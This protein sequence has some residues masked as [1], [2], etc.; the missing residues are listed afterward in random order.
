MKCL[1][2]EEHILIHLRLLFITSR[3]IYPQLTLRG[4]IASQQISQIYCP[5]CLVDKL[6]CRQVLESNQHKQ[7]K[8]LAADENGIIPNFQVS[9][10][11]WPT[12]SKMNGIGVS[13]TY[14][15][16]CFLQQSTVVVCQST[17]CNPESARRIILLLYLQGLPLMLNSLKL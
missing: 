11:L 2:P 9:I 1:C 16:T 12:L 17:L 14:C 7:T 3:W 13:V 6:F 15:T 8:Q 10:S 5:T 4:T